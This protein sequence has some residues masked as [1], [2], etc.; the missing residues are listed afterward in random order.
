MMLFL[1]Q[2]ENNS[3]PAILTLWLRERLVAIH[4][5]VDTS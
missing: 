3:Q 1:E 5:Q 2:K 4:S